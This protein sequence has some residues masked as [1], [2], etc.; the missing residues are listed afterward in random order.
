M[1]RLG[2]ERYYVQGGDWGGIIVQIMAA[3]FPEKIIGV[4]SHMCFV[5]SFL[6]FTKTYIGSFF[7]SLVGIPKEQ[8]DYLYPMSEKFANLLL[9]TG[10]MHL[11]ATKPD[12][13]GNISTLLNYT[14]IYL[15]ILQE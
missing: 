1:S 9:E 6:Q 13:I 2:F 15:I 3:T 12:T 4:H 8:E 7:P 11:Q 14:F 5:N 10:Y